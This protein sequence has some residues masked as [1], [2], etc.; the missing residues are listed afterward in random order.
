M[1]KPVGGRGN[2]APYETTHV[3]V[4]VPI[5]EQVQTLIDNYRSSI[6]GESKETTNPSNLAKSSAEALELCREVL[7]QKKNAKISLV[8]LVNKLYNT[9]Y[10]VDDLEN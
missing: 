4:P 6:L 2:T 7:K 10:T 1:P 5:K 3:R 9:N 8:K